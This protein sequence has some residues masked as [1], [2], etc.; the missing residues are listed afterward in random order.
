M[1]AIAREFIYIS[2]HGVYG[3]CLANAKC[4]PKFASQTSHT[5][6]RYGE[7]ASLD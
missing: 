1:L 6:E 5:P 7:I 4:S 2:Q 3:S